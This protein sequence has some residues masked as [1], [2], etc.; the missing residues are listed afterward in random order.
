[1]INDAARRRLAELAAAVAPAR[2]RVTRHPLFAA[3]ADV[4]DLRLYASRHVFAVWDFMCLLKRLQRELSCVE[5]PWQ[6]PAD[7][8]AAR[9]INEIVLAEETDEDG[10]GG[11][12]SHYDLYRRGMRELG[13]DE[14]PIERFQR[15]LAQLGD[16]ERAL[17][18]SEAPAACARFVR[19]TWRIASRAELHEVAV[20]FA[21]GRE[22]VMPEMFG[23]L[24]PEAERC[25]DGRFATLR[26]YLERHIQ[27][28]GDVHTPHAL[29]LLA[30][31]GADDVCKWNEMRDAAEQALDE[32][33]R[34]WDGV[35]AELEA[36]R[37]IARR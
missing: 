8:E 10:A 14:L 23:A 28:D 33:A 34:L 26:H 21:L 19:A 16:V 24:L 17:D 29:A 3:L 27:L 37:A 18:A 30:R 20:V 9:L 1:M 4:D 11:H 6:P 2:A 22:D 7:R 31:L 13:A 32:R 36:R 25:A 5:L 12:C 35:L 15:A